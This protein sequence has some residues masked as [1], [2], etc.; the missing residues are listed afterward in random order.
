M[1]FF[2][3]LDLVATFQDKPFFVFE[4][5]VRDY[6]LIQGLYYRCCVWGHFEDSNVR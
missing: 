2:T 6:T 3:M 1:I 5:E 4:F